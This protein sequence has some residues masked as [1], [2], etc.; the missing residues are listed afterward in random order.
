MLLAT[1]LLHAGFVAQPGPVMCPCS[2]TSEAQKWSFKQTKLMKFSNSGTCLGVGNMSSAVLTEKCGVA[3]GLPA[4]TQ[5]WAIHFNPPSPTGRID[6][7]KPQG[8]PF[9]QLQWAYDSSLCLTSPNPL[10]EGAHLDV[11][12]CLSGSGNSS[13]MWQVFSV[14]LADGHIIAAPPFTTRILCVANSDVC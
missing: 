1:L 10:K 14:G 13:T 6:K 4:T 8:G 5:E 9:T 2:E 11:Q 3:G 7:P 12:P